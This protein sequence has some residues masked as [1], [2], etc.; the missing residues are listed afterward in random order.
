VG[1]GLKLLGILA[2]IGAV[3]TPV[4]AARPKL[5]QIA[6][7]FEIQTLDG[8][9]LNLADL[10]GQV[11]VLNFWAT[12]CGPCRQELPLLDDYYKAKKKQ[13]LRVF[14]ITTE[15]S[16]PLSQLKPLAAALTIPMVRHLKG[17][18]GPLGGVP[19]NFIIDRAGVAVR[20]GT[21]CVMPLLARYGL[22]ATCRASFAMY[23][24]KDEVETLAASL[25][26]AQEFFA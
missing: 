26:K 3:A 4:S 14:A 11:V 12:W 13:G 7:P 2:L 23:N 18:Y 6:P 1:I 21:H 22:T 19:T 16:L 24:T 25:V 15:D 17:P 5:D 10:K 20:A 8:T 9:K